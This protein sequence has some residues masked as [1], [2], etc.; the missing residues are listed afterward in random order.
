MSFGEYHELP[1]IEIIGKT[2]TKTKKIHWHLCL[3]E[4]SSASHP[5]FERVVLTDSSH[6]WLKTWKA[7]ELDQ[8]TVEVEEPW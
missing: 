5:N 8:P 3:V 7:L 4:G 1:V 2:A 6:V